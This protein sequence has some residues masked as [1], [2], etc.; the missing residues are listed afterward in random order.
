MNDRLNKTE[1][2]LSSA[3]HGFPMDKCNEDSSLEETLKDKNKDKSFK[4][5]IC[6]KKLANQFYFIHS[7]VSF[8]K[9]FNLVYLRI[10][11]IFIV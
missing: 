3:L 10:F 6:L 1:N 2:I 4:P 5:P 8:I 7:N 9:E 11:P